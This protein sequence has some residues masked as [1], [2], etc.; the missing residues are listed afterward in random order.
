MYL[1]LE[2][3]YLGKIKSRGCHFQGQNQNQLKA[4]SDYLKQGSR[5]GCI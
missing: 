5:R 1:I 4:V 2:G 3:S